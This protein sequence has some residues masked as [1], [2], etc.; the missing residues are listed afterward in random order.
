[1]SFAKSVALVKHQPCDFHRL[2]LF[3]RFCP[4]GFLPFRV[5]RVIEKAVAEKFT[6]REVGDF[7][8][9]GVQNRKIYGQLTVDGLIR[10]LPD[11]WLGNGNP[12]LGEV[13]FHLLEKFIRLR[14]W[15]DNLERFA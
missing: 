14:R 2:D 9:P 13:L 6:T 10:A 3:R 11:N 7:H 15:R 12:F 1:M 4:D 5:Q 8:Q